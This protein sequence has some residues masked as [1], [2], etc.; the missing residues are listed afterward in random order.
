MNLGPL[1]GKRVEAAATLLLLCVRKGP[2]ETQWLPRRIG[3]EGGR[4]G[5]SEIDWF[6]GARSALK[7]EGMMG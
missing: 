3:H 6:W 2:F 5:I 4:I 7:K 1:S